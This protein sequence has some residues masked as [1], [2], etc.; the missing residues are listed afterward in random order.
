[1]K[2][3]E[4]KFNT[5]DELQLFGQSWKSDMTSKAIICLIHGFG[6]HSGRYVQVAERL[7]K[8]GYSLITFDLRGHGKSPGLRGHISSY[9]ALLRDISSLLE[10]SKKRF[11]Q[12]PTFLY[13]H[14]W[15]GSLVLNY[16]LQ[17]KPQLKGVIV[18]GPW[19]QLAFEPPLYKVILSKIMNSI[20]PSFLQ[21]S[22]LDTKEL[23]HDSKIVKAY[24]K[25]PLV[26]SYISA[27]MFVNIYKSGRW[28][29]EHA[30]EFNLPLLLMHGGED[31]IISC[32]ASCEFAKKLIDSKNCTFK[33]WEGLYHEIH[34]EPKKEEV[35]KFIINWLDWRVLE[36]F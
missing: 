19:L 24:K 13:G 27:R 15:G 4:F 12:I 34:N 18:T 21:I 22:G 2:H 10:I 5:F 1:M 31:K 33:L 6:E 26:H 28:A 36:Q 17:Y 35:L 20:W 14:S 32:K 23:S 9:E 3:A 29:L 8:D 25:D 11:P 16:V 7:T 30:S